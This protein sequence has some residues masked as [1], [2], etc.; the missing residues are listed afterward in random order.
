[1]LCVRL[2]ISL[3][4]RMATYSFKSPAS[5]SCQPLCSLCSRIQFSLYCSWF[6]IVAA[7][8]LYTRIM[9]CLYLLCFYQYKIVQVHWNLHQ[10]QRLLT[11]GRMMYVVMDRRV[12]HVL[13]ILLNKKGFF[14]SE[15]VSQVR[16]P[17]QILWPF[18]I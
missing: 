7:I 5:L 15:I 4:S 14:F 11:K 13:Y 12:L 1:M 3:P 18:Y 6:I 8:K 9:C 10:R 16:N 17:K 2:C